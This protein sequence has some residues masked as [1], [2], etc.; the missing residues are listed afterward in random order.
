MKS[1][2]FLR[3][4]LSLVV[5]SLIWS[6]SSY[7]FA[8]AFS[9]PAQSPTGKYKLEVRTGETLTSLATK[10]QENNIINNADFIPLIS[11]LSVVPNLRA[12]IY[13]LDLPAKPDEILWQINNQKPGP[14]ENTASVSFIE[15]DTAEDIADKL[16][17][18]GIISSQDFLKYIQIPENFDLEKYEFLPSMRSDCKYG[19]IYKNC[20]KYYLEGYLFPDTYNFFKNSKAE[21]VTTKILQ[22]FS[23]KYWS[24]FR[25]SFNQDLKIARQ[26]LYQK[27]ILAS[28][29]EREVGRNYIKA[30]INDTDLDLE[31]RQV[32]RVYLNRVEQKMRWQA[33]PTVWYGVDRKKGVALDGDLNWGNSKYKTGY[34][35]YTLVGY[36]VGPIANPSLNSLAAATT[37]GVNDY[38]FFVS[39]RSGKMYFGKDYAQHNRNIATV[40]EINK[41]LPNF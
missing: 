15:G 20:P 34:N 13:E 11:R 35:T 10:L 14:Q 2:V 22:N 38:L 37:P 41:S 12:G 4:I 32:A 9:T 27:L 23:N 5:L 8:G 24:K 21:V 26:E 39:D 17:K 29:V 19:E 33:D 7:G 25:S 6:I 1:I 31:R 36:P 28:V 16:E 18:S 30:I 3:I 40:R